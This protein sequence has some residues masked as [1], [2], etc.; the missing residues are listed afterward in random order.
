MKK[1]NLKRIK[2][3]YN[4]AYI[5]WGVL[6]FAAM[7]LAMVIF[8]KDSYALEFFVYF[9]TAGIILAILTVL[10]VVIV[11][12]IRTALL[13]KMI[14]AQGDLESF[15][16]ED[17]MEVGYSHNVF[18]SANWFLWNRGFEYRIFH[19]A[20]IRAC[21]THPNQRPGNTYAVCDL[22]TDSSATP[23]NL[24]YTYVPGVDLP[25]MIQ[26]WLFP[27]GVPAYTA[28]VQQP[29]P[30]AY[31]QPAAPGYAQPAAYTQPQVQPV[32]MSGPV[33]PACGRSLRVGARFCEFCGHKL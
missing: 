12:L 23:L 26:G 6:C 10:T 22:Y 28:P 1:T 33:C 9:L 32:P 13:K 5:W 31:V 17:F 19:R 8:L 15:N 20:H 30:A 29:A 7:M 11:S 21:L 25:G 4:G 16:Q 2:S 27:N 18:V 3:R 24:Y 14:R